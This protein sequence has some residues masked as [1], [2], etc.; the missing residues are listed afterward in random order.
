MQKKK[1]RFDFGSFHQF[2][3]FLFSIVRLAYCFGKQEHNNNMNRD[4]YIYTVRK[5][6]S[7]L[8]VLLAEKISEFK[9]EDNIHKKRQTIDEVGVGLSKRETVCRS[10][11][12]LKLMSIVKIRTEKDRIG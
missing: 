8:H 1:A 6:L 11:I 10:S 4:I 2:F 3:F 7:C 12:H 5:L 9:H